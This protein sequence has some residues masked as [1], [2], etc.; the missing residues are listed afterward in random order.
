MGII[1]EFPPIR[2]T[3]DGDELKLGSF[4]IVGEGVGTSVGWNVG[5]T[6][7]DGVEDGWKDGC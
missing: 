1:I 4:V 6:D 2:N 7:F 3:L 5:N